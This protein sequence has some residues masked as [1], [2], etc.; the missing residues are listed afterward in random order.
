MPTNLEKGKR[1]RLKVVQY[2]ANAWEFII[3]LLIGL[4]IYIVVRIA[5][6]AYL[7]KGLGLSFTFCDSLA[8]L[9]ILLI[10]AILMIFFI[11]FKGTRF[12][13]AAAVWMPA[14]S[15]LVFS[16][17]IR[18]ITILTQ[19]ESID[20]WLGFLPF[21]LPL[22]LMVFYWIFDP[23]ILWLKVLTTL[24]LLGMSVFWAIDIPRSFEEAK[25]VQTVVQAYQE[26]NKNLQEYHEVAWDDAPQSLI[27]GGVL[28]LW[29]M[30]DVDPEDYRIDKE[31]S[32]IINMYYIVEA[33][34]IIGAMKNGLRISTQILD[35]SSLNHVSLHYFYKYST[36]RKIVIK[37]FQYTG[38]AFFLLEFENGER[39]IVD[40]VLIRKKDKE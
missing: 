18:F 31:I 29:H 24:L 30:K 4:G 19:P 16:D 8:E 20:A 7:T 12:H 2:Y 34:I 11:W 25:N 26:F 33:D 28:S 17:L 40:N 9:S 3:R 39:T 21:I 14:I 22:I 1:Q 15:C 5:L 6:M 36:E 35:F 37:D 23:E 27:S 38:N 10:T 13:L 32:G